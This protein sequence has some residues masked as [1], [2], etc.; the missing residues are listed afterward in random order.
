MPSLKNI[1][2]VDFKIKPE[3]RQKQL[4]KELAP[5]VQLLHMDEVIEKGR[6]TPVDFTP[7]KANRSS[8]PTEH[9]TEQHTVL[10]T[11]VAP[12]PTCARTSIQSPDFR[13]E[14]CGIAS[15]NRRGIASKEAKIEEVWGAK[16]AKS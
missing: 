13:N 9:P 7:P 3:D 11:F 1:I 8:Y 4:A 5:G 6:L 15:K 14:R 16:K 2:Y 12:L 10:H